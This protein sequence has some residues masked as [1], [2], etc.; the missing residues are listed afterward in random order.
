ME[1]MQE[2]MEELQSRI[3]ELE[4]EKGVL[5]FENWRLKGRAGELPNGIY[6]KVLRYADRYDIHVKFEQEK[7]GVSVLERGGGYC[8]YENSGDF[9]RSVGGAYMYLDRKEKI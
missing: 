9:M 2:R 4:Y 7:T 8:L 5:E 3:K 6:L 1:E